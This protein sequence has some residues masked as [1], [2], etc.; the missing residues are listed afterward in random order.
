MQG[1]LTDPSRIDSMPPAQQERIRQ[2][3]RARDF[4]QAC[5]KADRQLERAG[6]APRFRKE[7]Q[8][9]LIAKIEA[10]GDRE[11]L[12]FPED[13]PDKMRNAIAKAIAA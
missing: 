2:G 12:L 7:W 10:T 1:N 11:A 13:C 6:K 9:R 5:R 4:S 3:Q 8:D